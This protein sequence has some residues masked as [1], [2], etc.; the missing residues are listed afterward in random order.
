MLNASTLLQA[1][2]RTPRSAAMSRPGM[3][4]MQE[5]GDETP[6]EMPPPPAAMPPPP[7]AMPSPPASTDTD[8]GFDISKY[9]ITLSLGGL[10]VLVK[11]LSYFGILDSGN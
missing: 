10:F 9:S 2:L 8:G 4:R 6:A 7:A 3:L 1:V 5:G 11:L